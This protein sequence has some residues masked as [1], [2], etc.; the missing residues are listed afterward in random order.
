M[1]LAVRT[2]QPHDISMRKNY[3]KIPNQIRK[4]HFTLFK[5]FHLYIFFHLFIHS[6]IYF[7]FV[8]TLHA[9][10]RTNQITC[11]TNLINLLLTLT[12]LIFRQRL[13]GLFY[14]V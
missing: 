13:S 9:I 4:F 2:L 6:F 3:L 11:F 12:E 7:L 8:F 10:S 1:H 5:N 14:S